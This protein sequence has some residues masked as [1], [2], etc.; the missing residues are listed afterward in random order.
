MILDLGNDFSIELDPQTGTPRKFLALLDG[1]WSS[2]SVLCSIALVVGGKE[3]RGTTGGLDYPGAKEIRDSRLQ[4]VPAI[5]GYASLSRRVQTTLGSWNLSWLWS[6]SVPDGWINLELDISTTEVGLPPLRGVKLDMQ[7]ELQDKSRWNIEVPG[8]QLRGSVPLNGLPSNIGVSP[9]TGSRGSSGVISLHRDDNFNVVLWP[10]CLTEPAQITI[11]QNDAGLTVSHAIELAASFDSPNSLSV[12]ALVFSLAKRTWESTKQALIEAY[13]AFGITAPESRPDW[14][15]SAIIL[16]AQIGFSPF[17]GGHTYEPYKNLSDLKDDLPRLVGLGFDCIQLMPRQPY[18]SYNIHDLFDLETTYAPENELREFIAHCHDIG[19]RVILDILMHGVIDKSS[20]RQAA[21]GV[22]RG[23]LAQRLD[24]DPGDILATDPNDRTPFQISWSR[25]VLDFEPYWLS[26]SPQHSK[27]LDTNPDWFF[28]DSA[29][30]VTGVYTHA[31]DTSSPGFSDYFARAVLNLVTKLG[32][33]GFRFDAPTYNN[34]PNWSESTR[35]HASSSVLA[36]NT[37]FSRLRSDLKLISSD[38]L[39]YT[40]PSGVAMRKHMDVN[41]NYDEAWLPSALLNPSKERREWTVATAHHLVNW[42]RDRDSLL[43][44]GSLTAHHIDS[45][46]T[47]WW[48][49]WG[50]KWRREQFGLQPTIALTHA[51]LLGG[52]P[53]MIFIGGEIGM[54]DELKKVKELRIKFPALL[55]GSSEFEILAPDAQSV[56]SVT[57]RYRN[58]ITVALVNLSADYLVTK[59]WLPESRATWIDESGAAGTY[60]DEVEFEPWS[61]RIFTSELGD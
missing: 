36:C 57:R 60:G 16:E 6:R 53:F 30:E 39:L 1:V 59:V 34:F 44:I 18:P 55:K 43:P 29:G 19:I 58:E 13:P 52:G 7:I 28:R 25:H 33:D 45:H 11:G 20:V 31:L 38:I 32:I 3:L 49:Q 22:R 61:T 8:N 10:L 42:L 5:F 2:V 14:I 37:L 41:Y 12:Q 40:E 4:A 15:G 27:L 56:F 9:S 46:D 26:A 17:W 50:R 23:P 47:F 35:N 51:F 21:D 24:E 48:P 54:E